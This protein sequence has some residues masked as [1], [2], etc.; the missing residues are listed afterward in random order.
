MST[1]TLGIKIRYA[2][3]RW[4]PCFV[5]HTGDPHPHARQILYTVR[6]IDTPALAL[7]KK[8]NDGG[9]T[10]I[11]RLSRFGTRRQATDD[12]TDLTTTDS[13]TGVAEPTHDAGPRA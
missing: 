3:L 12:G 1:E 10:R 9:Q 6:V 8:V 7:Q 11:R 2:Y 5:L 4:R 13:G